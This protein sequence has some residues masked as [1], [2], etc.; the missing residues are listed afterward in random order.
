MEEIRAYLS[1]LTGEPVSPGVPLRL[2]SVQR[3]AFS[4]WARQGNIPLRLGVIGSG[5]PFLLEDLLAPEATAPGV[6]APAFALAPPGARPP[7]VE[8]TASTAVGVDIEDVSSMPHADD[9]REHP[10]YQ[11]NFTAT[12]IAYCLLQANVRASLCGTW[13][14]KEAILKTGVASAPAGHLK[15]I[16]ITRDSAGRPIFPQCSL[17]ISHTATTAIAMC[18][19]V[20]HPVQRSGYMAHTS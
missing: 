14:A 1:R 6:M 5:T 3:A 15:G 10:F 7:A 20:V 18:S 2:R 8:A 16:E 19:A 12:E 4:S 11:D 17:S 9:Y 13:A